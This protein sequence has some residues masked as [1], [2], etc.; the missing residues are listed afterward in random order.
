MYAI[1]N[2]S[3]IL[4]IKDNGKPRS[5]KEMSELNLITDHTIVIDKEKIIDILPEK[6]LKNKYPNIK[7]IDAQYNLVMPGLCD[8][9]THLVF[10]GSRHVEF[11]MR[12]SGIDYMEIHR[13]GGGIQSSVNATRKISE[14]KLYRT[15]LKRLKDLFKYGTT[16]VEIKSGYGLDLETEMKQ[17][18]VA[19][20]LKDLNPDIKTTFLGAHSKPEEFDTHTEFIEY[21][22]KK[23][24]PVIADEGLAD[25][26]DIFCEKGVFSPDDARKHLNEGKKYGLIPKLH[27]DELAYSKAAEV[28]SEVGAISADHLL[29]ASEDAL[30][31]MKEN[32]VIATLLPATLY[33]LAKKEYPKAR[34]MI[35]SIKLPVALASD[36]N[37]GSCYCE[38][39]FLT[40]H[41]ACQYMKMT[42]AE[43]IVATT[44]NGAYAMGLEKD[45]GSIQIGK[46][47]DILII[48]APNYQYLPYHFGI[49]PVKK[50]IKRGV[51]LQ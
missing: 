19:N 34:L 51:V 2:A 29:C 39:L 44:I 20:K 27:A 40:M 21:L 17:L 23:V 24:L 49:N 18:K 26:I 16:S 3:E 47:A 5:G 13:K 41:I 9:H 4:Q 15:S 1:V 38:N 10:G 6:E 28:A 35:D 31:S 36:F 12:A 48:D 22:N 14:E 43:V 7:L 37:P 25:F 11:E 45:C 50:V 8:S 30:S 32:N 33:N 46:N 42:P